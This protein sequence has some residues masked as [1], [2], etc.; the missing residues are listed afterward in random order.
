MPVDDNLLEKT[1]QKLQELSAMIAGLK[2]LTEDVWSRIVLFTCLFKKYFGEVFVY[3]ETDYVQATRKE[4]AEILDIL[5]M[6]K[7]E[8]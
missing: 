5:A 8:E 6:L 2:A 3:E 4:L 7:N 1:G